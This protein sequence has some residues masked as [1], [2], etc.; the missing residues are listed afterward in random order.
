MLPIDLDFV[1]TDK[2]DLRG[3]NSFIIFINSLYLAQYKRTIQ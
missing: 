1:F 3:N 2:I